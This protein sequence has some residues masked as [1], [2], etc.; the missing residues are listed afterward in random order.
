MAESRP[1]TESIF[2]VAALFEGGL[3]LVAWCLGL[4]LDRPPWAQIDWSAAALGWGLL[5]TLPLALGLLV[6]TR[7]PLGPF[8]ALNDFVRQWVLPLFATCTTWQIAVISLLAG[9]GEEALFRGVVQAGIE[10]LSGAPWLALAIA[11]ALFGLAHAVTATYAILAGLIGV[12]LGWIW[13][14]TGNLLVPIVTHAV[15]D[16]VALVYLLGPTR[17]P[18]ADDTSDALSQDDFGVV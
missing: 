11:S 1:P 13:L 10:Q 18:T 9:L 4:L 8:K 5:A 12:Y 2:R 7:Y 17:R 6:I 15:Y 16:F 3:V 14:E